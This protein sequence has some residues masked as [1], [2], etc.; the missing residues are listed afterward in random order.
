MTNDE[1]I[2]AIEKFQR[3]RTTLENFD[4]LTIIGNHDEINDNEHRLKHFQ[5]KLS[6]IFKDN[7]ITFRVSIVQDTFFCCVVT[8]YNKSTFVTDKNFV[9]KLISG[10]E[11]VT[12]RIRLFLN[13]DTMNKLIS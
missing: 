7:I 2:E 10:E 5:V 4:N 9:D 8:R 11:P 6:E 3:C 1:A 13:S 12:D